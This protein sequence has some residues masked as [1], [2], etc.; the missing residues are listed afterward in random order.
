M[1]NESIRKCICCGEKYKF[2]IQCG[3]KENYSWKNVYDTENCMEITNILMNFRDK[4]SGLSKA[5]AK[6]QIE[7]YPEELLEKIKNNNSFTAI[8]IKEIL[9]E[10]ETP[11]E[12]NT[13]EEAPVEEV[14]KEEVHEEEVHEE[15][16]VSEK[17]A[18]EAGE[19]K[20]RYTP[21]AQETNRPKR[22]LHKNTK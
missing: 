3:G 12:T 7:K 19:N 2:C 13:Q 18:D 21:K 22:N 16:S 9:K 8:G 17:P 10:E 15:P 14:N 5:A 1:A 20:G 6:K 4:K 11:V